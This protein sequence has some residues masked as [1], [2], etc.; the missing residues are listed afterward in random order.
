V[1]A[2]GQRRAV[3]GA[4]EATFGAFTHWIAPARSAPP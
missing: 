4:A 3:L 2:H 1:R